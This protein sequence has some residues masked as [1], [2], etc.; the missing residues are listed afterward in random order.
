MMEFVETFGGIDLNVE[1][2]K[3]HLIQIAIGIFIVVAGGLLL[4]ILSPQERSSTASID[5]IQTQK[6]KILLDFSKGQNTEISKDWIE[7]KNEY[8]ET[9]VGQIYFEIYRF[10]NIQS[11]LSQ[12]SIIIPF[13]GLPDGDF[14]IKMT[15]DDA[16][17][18]SVSEPTEARKL[19]AIRINLEKMDKGD[20]FEVRVESPDSFFTNNHSVKTNLKQVK[21]VTPRTLHL[22]LDD[23]DLK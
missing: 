11:D 16:L 4:L 1:W 14:S 17:I 10:Y 2:L 6:G 22:Y 12:F 13:T 8:N 9:V 21:A 19:G 23:Q 20:S 18:A 7:E 5:A 3:T 15:N